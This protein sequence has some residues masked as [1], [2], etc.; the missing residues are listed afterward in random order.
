MNIVQRELRAA[1]AA[2]R[3]GKVCV[4]GANKY[5]KFKSESMAGLNRSRARLMNVIRA[6]N[7]ILGRV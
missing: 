5:G 7:V 3:Y 1:T 6:T 4:R 2:Y